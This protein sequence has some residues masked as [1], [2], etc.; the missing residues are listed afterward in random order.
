MLNINII[1]NK[2]TT[3]KLKITTIF[4]L[5]LYNTFISNRISKIL[6][7]SNGGIGIRLNTAKEIL[8]TIK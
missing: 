2:I 6:E 1:N 7:P 4:L 8:I 3:I 5:V